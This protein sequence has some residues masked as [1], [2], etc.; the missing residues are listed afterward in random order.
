MGDNEIKNEKTLY[1]TK[2]FNKNTFKYILSQAER[3]KPFRKH[4]TQ[5][6]LYHRKWLLFTRKIIALKLSRTPNEQKYEVKS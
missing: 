1:R 4:L 3:M 5:V 6:R 2:I